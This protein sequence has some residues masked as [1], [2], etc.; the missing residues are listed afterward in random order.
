LAL[1]QVI[2]VNDDIILKS[3]KMF[4]WF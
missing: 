1:G 2:K 3:R 4:I